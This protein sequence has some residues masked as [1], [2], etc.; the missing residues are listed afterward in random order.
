VCVGVPPPPAADACR[1]GAAS[2]L[3]GRGKAKTECLLETVVAGATAGTTVRCKDGDATCDADPTRGRCGLAVSW[4]I[5][6]TDPRLP[7]CTARGVRRVKAAATGKPRTAALSARD[8][9][10]NGLGSASGALTRGPSLLLTPPDMTPDRCTTPVRVAVDVRKR[11]KK[12]RPG[13]LKLATRAFGTGKSVDADTIR[14]L[15]MP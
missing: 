14:L 12:I 5:N 10:L 9:L 1:Q 2:C 8:A 15:C 7:R 4:C 6:N 3:P 13:T 11:G